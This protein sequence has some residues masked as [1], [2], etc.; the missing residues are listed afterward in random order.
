MSSDELS[1]GISVPV[2]A[3]G[4]TSRP[5]P[6][7]SAL[8]VELV[9]GIETEQVDKLIAVISMFSGVQSVLRSSGAETSLSHWKEEYKREVLTR[10]KKVL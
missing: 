8:V 4:T 2:P 5:H 6:L 3:G 10:I 9:A 1:S 7:D